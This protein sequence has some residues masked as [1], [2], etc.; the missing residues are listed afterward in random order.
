MMIGTITMQSA[1]D[2]RKYEHFANY[3]VAFQG[4]AAARGD[5]LGGTQHFTVNPEAPYKDGFG[6]KEDTFIRA[7]LGIVPNPMGLH[8]NLHNM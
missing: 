8:P 6:R 3:L 5:I 1:V 7:A 2:L 4:L